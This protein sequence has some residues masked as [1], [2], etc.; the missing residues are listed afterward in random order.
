MGKLLIVIEEYFMSATVWYRI[1]YSRTIVYLATNQGVVGSIPASR[2]IYVKGSDRKVWPFS[3][4][5]SICD[6]LRFLDSW[7][8]P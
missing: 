6:T 2:T 5:P 3:F 1:G 7:P 8:Y 4:L